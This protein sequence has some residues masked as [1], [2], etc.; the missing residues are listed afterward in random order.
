MKIKSIYTFKLHHI[1]SHKLYEVYSIQQYSITIYNDLNKLSSYPYNWFE[2][3]VQVKREFS[4]DKILN[5]S[6]KSVIL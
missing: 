4:I 5:P 3:S 2:D 6:N 1:T